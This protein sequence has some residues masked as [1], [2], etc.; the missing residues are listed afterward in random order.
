MN[1][2]AVD[3]RLADVHVQH[4][5]RVC[6]FEPIAV[7]DDEVSPLS[8]FQGSCQGVHVACERCPKGHAKHGF[9]GREC[10][11]HVE[12]LFR[13]AVGILAGDCCQ[14]GLSGINILD[15]KVR[16]KWNHAQLVL[17]V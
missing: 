6:Q 15:G 3:V 11:V 14:I 1:L 13:V 2:F 17:Q 10:L 8:H 4:V 9:S 7:G 5:V 16:P 12:P